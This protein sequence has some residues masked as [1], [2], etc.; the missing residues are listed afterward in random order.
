MTFL[1]SVVGLAWVF[2]FGIFC[3]IAV[4]LSICVHRPS[5]IQ[6]FSA[7]SFPLPEFTREKRNVLHIAQPNLS[8]EIATYLTFDMKNTRAAETLF[9]LNRWLR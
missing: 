4:Y 7:A 9:N 1:P 2:S 3:F 8:V 5:H 6:N